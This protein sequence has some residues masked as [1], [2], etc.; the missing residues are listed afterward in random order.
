M[1]FTIRSVKAFLG[2]KG[3]TQVQ[4]LES[5]V[6]YRDWQASTVWFPT[7][8]S[9]SVVVASRVCRSTFWMSLG[10]PFFC[11]RVAIVAP[12]HLKGQLRQSPGSPNFRIFFR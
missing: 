2:L 3:H 1:A 9:T 7:R 6:P 4:V 10:V 8:V 12:D 11:A 5:K